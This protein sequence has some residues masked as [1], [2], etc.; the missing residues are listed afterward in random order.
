[1]V[2]F[3]NFHSTDPLDHRPHALAWSSRKL[4]PLTVEAGR[5]RVIPG[6]SRT[7]NAKS[8]GAPMNVRALRR[9]RGF[10]QR[11]FAGYFGFPLATLRHWERGN[12]R[13]TGP[14]L[15]LLHVIADNPRAVLLAVRKVRITQPGL[16]PAIEPR[17]SS[18][19][20]PG[21]RRPVW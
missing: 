3:R 20:P 8:R 18:R 9:R 2:R 19:A 13:P 4:L 5:K 1:M 12:R 17:R 21:A 16:L 11:E 10:T 7:K 15:V 6:I 14:A